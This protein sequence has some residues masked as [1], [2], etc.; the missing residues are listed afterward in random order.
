MTLF[1]LN[2]FLLLF[3][4]E[5]GHP[6]SGL[7]QAVRQHLLCSDEDWGIDTNGFDG[8]RVIA[9]IHCLLG[10]PDCFFPLTFAQ[11]SFTVRVAAVTIIQIQGQ[12]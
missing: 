7:L 2:G 11:R 4:A 9:G 5:C 1:S 10:I 8:L 12:V 6:E 3:D